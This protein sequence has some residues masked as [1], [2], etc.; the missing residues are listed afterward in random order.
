MPTAAAEER[1]IAATEAPADS[2]PLLPILTCV[3]AG[4]ALAL[5]PV[6]V[7][8]TTTGSWVCLQQPETLFYLQIAAQ[9][10]YNHVG[11]ISDP[12][13]AN[14]VT[15]FP[16]LQFVPFIFLARILGLS[17]FSIP[18]IWALVAGV[19]IGVGLYLVFW[20][21]LHRPWI[22]VG[23]T[24]VCLSD[25]GFCGP[26]VIVPQLKRLISALVIH[27]VGNLSS[28]PYFFFQ[29]RAPDSALDLPFLFFKPWL[30]RS[31]AN[32]RGA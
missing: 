6:L 26:L 31:R 9:A 1:P 4:L 28:I 32:V 25:S 8:R 24:I 3:A 13:V 29:W 23:L 7:W 19:G 21:F 15:F 27:P 14:G 12:V 17:T 11:Y 20:R 16:W 5:T 18:L 22:A 2:I 10:W 30:S